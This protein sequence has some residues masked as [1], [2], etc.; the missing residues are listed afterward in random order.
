[1]SNNAILR[2][3]FQLQLVYLFNFC[4]HTKSQSFHPQNIGVSDHQIS[5][6]LS[7]SLIFLYVKGNYF[8]IV[9][10]NLFVFKGL[11]FCRCVKQLV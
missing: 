3:A 2:W 4:F 6:G 1:M 8:V 7:L 9:L 5:N 10:N 11:C